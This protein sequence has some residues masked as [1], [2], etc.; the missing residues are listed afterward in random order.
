MFHIENDLFTKN[1]QL[2]AHALEKIITMQKVLFATR[3]TA[4]E[5]GVQNFF[6]IAALIS[7]MKM[8]KPKEYSSFVILMDHIPSLTKNILYGHMEHA[9][10]YSTIRTCYNMMSLGKEYYI[11]EVNEEVDEEQVVE[12]EEDDE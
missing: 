1:L 8:K 12:E 5:R 6:S 9:F 3:A 2:I 11:E 7:Y 4:V 10:P